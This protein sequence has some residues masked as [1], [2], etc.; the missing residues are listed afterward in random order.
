MQPFT[1]LRSHLAAYTKSLGVL[2]AKCMQETHDVNTLRSRA[3]FAGCPNMHQDQTTA[4]LHKT[5]SYTKGQSTQNI[6]KLLT[7]HE[8]RGRSLLLSKLGCVA[9]YKMCRV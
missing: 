4:W 8:E 2:L 7:E 1:T 6:Y 9:M 3:L 5:A